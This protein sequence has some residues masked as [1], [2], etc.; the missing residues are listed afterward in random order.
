[1]K[2]AIVALLTILIGCALAL[3]PHPR[4]VEK[5]LC[6]GS[7]VACGDSEKAQEGK[8]GKTAARNRHGSEWD[9]SLLCKGKPC[10]TNTVLLG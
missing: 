7:G 8:T 1:M 6:T 4:F 10:L 5:H 3:C 9:S 2:V